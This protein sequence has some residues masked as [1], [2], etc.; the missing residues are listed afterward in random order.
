MTIVECSDVSTRKMSLL[1]EIKVF[2]P[3]R[4]FD[5]L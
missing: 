5:E 2:Y 1:D 4:C 3:R